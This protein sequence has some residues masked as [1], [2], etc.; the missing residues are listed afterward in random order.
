MASRETP[1]TKAA[2]AARVAFEVHEY[3]HDPRAESYG[4]EVATALNLDPA[5][6]FETLV[7]EIELAPGDLVA[8]TGAEV[9][10]L[11]RA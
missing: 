11:R 9:R 4:R 3:A 1:A 10:P 7:V 5:R 8:L 6:V 2:R